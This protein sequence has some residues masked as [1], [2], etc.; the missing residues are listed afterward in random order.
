MK[1]YREAVKSAVS[2]LP[3]GDTKKIVTVSLVQVSLSF[4]DL[5]GVALIGV[6]GALSITGIKGA[7]IGD[8][9]GAALRLL[10][11][12]GLSFYSQVVVLAVMAALLLIT[13]TIL[14][15]YFS[16]RYLRFLATRS[17]LISTTLY[18]KLISQNILEVQKRNTQET[19]FIVTEG[20]R[21][22]TIGILGSIVFLVS[23]LSLLIVLTAGLFFLDPVVAIVTF[24][25]FSG[26]AFFFNNKI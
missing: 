8:R 5:F 23:D 13:R 11:L 21:R 17:A 10:N 3:E 4:L 19:L 2:D 1:K 25:L 7:Q 20:V 18:S 6:I 16:Q 24:F 9:T 26:V 14:S 15:M 22:I 12:D